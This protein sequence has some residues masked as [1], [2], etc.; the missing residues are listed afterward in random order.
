M[1]SRFFDEFE[2]LGEPNMPID[3]AMLDTREFRALLGRL[4]ARSDAT[5]RNHWVVSFFV[6]CS[7]VLE[8]PSPPLSSSSFASSFP[9]PLEL[10]LPP[11]PS[12]S[13]PLSSPL[14]LSLLP[15][16]FLSLS[17]K[18]DYIQ[19]CC[20]CSKWRRVR[21]HAAAVAAREVD[22]TCSFLNDEGEGDEGEGDMVAN[23]GDD[24]VAAAPPPPRR[25]FV[26]CD[27]PQSREETAG[28]HYASRAAV[29]GMLAS[30]LAGTQVGDG[31]VQRQKERRGG[32]AAVSTAPEGEA[33]SLSPA[34]APPPPPPPPS[35][36]SSSK[37]PAAAEQKQGGEGSLTALE[38][39]RQAR[40]AANRAYYEGLGLGLAGAAAAAAATEAAATT[41]NGGGR[42]KRQK[43]AGEAPPPPPAAAEPPPHFL[44]HDHPSILAAA[45]DLARRAAAATAAAQLASARER[46]RA[47]VER[48][49]ARIESLRAQLAAAE[50]QGD[51]E[52]AAEVAAAEEAARAVVG[53]VP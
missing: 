1:I 40:M 41:G 49:R 35:V 45:R 10:T 2:G 3:R 18:C 7:P 23:D 14:S 32:E 42:E 51:E 6:P 26:T 28:I 13:P 29:E 44:P 22:W 47:A 34:V 15:S 33:P 31:P 21:S 24:A 12:L 25:P 17:R 37:R 20:E 53:T 11:S 39:A 36:P 46:L 27:T 52:G 9:R 16:V 50:A 19:Q 30:G 38:L 4:R 8:L 5:A 43:G 48:R